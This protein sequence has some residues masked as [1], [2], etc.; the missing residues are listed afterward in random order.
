MD[1]SDKLKKLGAAVKKALGR[2][3][4]DLF[5]SN[6]EM[7]VLVP[8]HRICEAMLKLRD[9][10]LTGMNQLMDIC[11]A[12]YLDRLERFD[13]VY[14][15]LSLNN[16][17]RLRVRTQTDDISHVPSI[18]AIYSSAGWFEREVWDMFGIKFEAHPD[19]RRILTDYGFEG[20]PLRKDFPL[21]GHVEV[22]YSDELKRVVY[23]PLKKGIR[24]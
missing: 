12:D 23:E 11:G 15:L 19:L 16:N 22:R 6:G 9:D 13:V 21:M 24:S 1:Q 7:N 4:L 2:D 8:R 5:V 17:W 14:H 10:E 3:C 20:H 18:I